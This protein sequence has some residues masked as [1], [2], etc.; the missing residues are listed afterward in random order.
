MPPLGPELPHRMS[1]MLPAEH[2]GVEVRK[3]RALGSVRFIVL[4][5]SHLYL[6]KT[7]C[8]LA[9]KV[10]RGCVSHKPCFLCFSHLPRYLGDI[11]QNVHYPCIS[12]YSL[13]LN[14]Y[15]AISLASIGSR[16]WRL[17]APSL[18][19]VQDKQHPLPLAK[20]VLGTLPACRLG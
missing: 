15:A 12:I 5:G 4:R 2:S 8:Q 7:L 13:A 3:F 11:R 20:S 10:H 16:P 14:D 17:F 19:V 6:T 18:L 9:E 1:C